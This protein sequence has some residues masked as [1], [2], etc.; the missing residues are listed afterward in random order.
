MVEINFLLFIVFP[1]VA[2]ITLIIGTTYRYMARKFTFSSL[3]S[4]FLGDDKLGGIGSMLWHYGVLLVLSGHFIA[5]FFTGIYEQFKG[6]NELIHTGM[7][8]MRYTAGL[9]A[10]SG[11]TLLII[12]RLMNPRLRAV[13]TT[14]DWVVLT[15]L[16]AQLLMGWNVLLNHQNQGF[17]F[18]DSVAPWLRSIFFLKP[19]V[20][21]VEWYVALHMLNFFLLIFLIPFSR[22]VHLFTFPIGYL[23]RPYQVVVWNRNRRTAY[24]Q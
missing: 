15:L 18:K 14:V 16:Y 20:P 1:Y 3:S 11:L 12:R 10:F 19:F 5:F 7:E 4:Q 2:L 21:T 17:W 23:F 24:E 13:T 8:I 6:S 22:L 9:M